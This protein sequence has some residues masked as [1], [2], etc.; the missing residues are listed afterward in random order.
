MRSTIYM[1]IWAALL[2]VHPLTAQTASLNGAV[3]DADSGTPL[4]GANIRLVDTLLGA[5]TDLEGQFVLPA[6]PVG[7]HQIEISLIGYATLIKTVQVISGEQVHLTAALTPSPL[8]AYGRNADPSR[9]GLLGG[10]L[11]G[12]APIRLANPAQPH[13]PADAATGT[14][15]HH[16]PARRRR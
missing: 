13:G 8:L 11:A 7:T 9:P 4:P 16:R 10:F 15:P 5:T 14:R 1:S 2:A 6:V 3:T 12:G